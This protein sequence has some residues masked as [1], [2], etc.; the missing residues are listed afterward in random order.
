M[1]PTLGSDHHGRI[2]LAALVTCLTLLLGGC[3]SERTTQAPRPIEPATQTSTLSLPFEPEQVGR[4][5]LLFSGQGQTFNGVPVA[6]RVEREEG[7]KH[8]VRIERPL[9]A[10]PLEH[11][12]EMVAGQVL[13]YL[14]PGV[15]ANDLLA[16]L[17]PHQVESVRKI[18]RTPTHVVCFDGS[19]AGRYEAVTAALR[20][21]GR[22]LVSAMGPDY[23]VRAT[24]TLPNDLNA[25]KQHN[26]NNTLNDADIDAP[27]AWDC[28]A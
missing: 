20:N 5:E 17:A 3:A 10:G 6:L 27:E 13:V 8:P 15:S 18:A 14:Q 21:E 26:L 19:V 2:C 25:A 16:F 1:L 23:I 4:R 22:R 28:A 24:A 9:M 12:Q 7:F 11:T